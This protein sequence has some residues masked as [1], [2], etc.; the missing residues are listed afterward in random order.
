MRKRITLAAVAAMMATLAGDYIEPGLGGE[1]SRGGIIKGVMLASTNAT[2]QADVKAV[3][4]FFTWGEVEVENVREH[5]RSELYD[6]VEVLTNWCDWVTSTAVTNIADSVTNIAYYAGITTVTNKA[7]R[8]VTEPVT[9]IVRET[10]IVKTVAITN[11]LYSLTAS[12]GVGTNFTPK[13]LG[14][15][16]R[17]L[18]EKHPVTIFWE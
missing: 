12:G 17:I 16:G 11:A 9:N 5:T 4:E 18:V 10:R 1:Y 8:T 14:A 15:G 6:K 7:L 2:Q 13:A 3:Y